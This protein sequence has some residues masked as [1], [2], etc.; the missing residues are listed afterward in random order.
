[1]K[2]KAE[3]ILLII[4]SLF[5][6]ALISRNGSLALM[7]IPFLV[8]LGAGLLAAP[9]EIRLHVTRQFSCIRAKEGTPITMS[10]NIENDGPSIPHLQVQEQAL[11]KM[12][13]FESTLDQRVTVPAKNSFELGYSFHAPRGR[14]SWETCR[15]VASDPFGLFEESFDLPAPGHTLV[16]P[17]QPALRRFRFHPR[18][19]LRTHGSNLSRLP[20]RGIDFWGVREYQT[21]DSLRLIHWRLAA[22]HPSLFFSKEFERE[23]M[24]DVGLLLD[25]RAAV[26]LTHENESLFEYSIQAA[27]ALAAN[28]IKAGNRVSLLT[29]GDRMVRVFP[30][31]GKRQLVRILDQLATCEPAQN[32][33]LNTLKYFPVRLF[34]SH[35]MIVVISPLRLNDFKT[36][37]WLRAGGYQVL[38]VSPNPVQLLAQNR[39]ANAVKSLAVRA[40]NV[41]RAVLLWRIRQIGVPVID[42]PVNQ[43]LE[44]IMGSLRMASR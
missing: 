11:A 19:T 43:S 17:E 20:G 22:R 44:K 1:M 34:P 3:L 4:I 27:A 39:P 10:L 13:I 28:F 15:V 41:E 2:A 18:S 7:A 16:L 8:Y 29:L 23:E 25:A 31:Y 26:N 9:G 14:Y 5:L 40:A 35:S 6:A 32:V 36:V 21:G 42:W 33:S 37:A 38:L 24:A 12:E 30:G